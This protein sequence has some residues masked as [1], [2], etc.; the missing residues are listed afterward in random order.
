MT[1]RHACLLVLL[2]VRAGLPTAGEISLTEARIQTEQALAFI[3]RLAVSFDG[4][5]IEGEEIRRLMRPQLIARL[6]AGVRMEPVQLRAWATLLADSEV[7]HLL[8]VQRATAAGYRPDMLGAREE[9][10]TRHRS[11]GEEAFV[12]TMAMQGV[13]PDVVV[14]KLAEN[15]MVNR[16]LAEQV[17][18][19]AEVSDEET[20]AY[21]NKNRDE[22]TLSAERRLWHILVADQPDLSKERRAMLRQNAEDM[23]KRLREGHD[24]ERLARSGSDCAS[25]ANG[26]DLGLVPEERLTKELLSVARK[27]EP[28]EISEVVQSRF[29]YHILMSGAAVPRKELPFAEARPRIL[30]RLQ[31]EKVGEAMERMR[32]MVREEANVKIHLPQGRE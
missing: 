31:G 5:M 32:Q 14:R 21:Y 9:L 20:R 22:F 28:G 4:G 7:D 29:G 18:Q 26:G 8:L 12:Q 10:D 24:F 19:M 6:Q 17:A 2:L 15:Q 3:P 30:R 13:E 27:L 16:W 25:A 1:R 23:L 11:M